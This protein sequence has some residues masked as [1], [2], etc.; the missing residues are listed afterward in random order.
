MCKRNA[1]FFR[2]TAFFRPTRTYKK[3]YISVK[4]IGGTECTCELPHGKSFANN[5]LSIACVSPGVT[6]Q[7]NDSHQ[8]DRFG[9]RPY[10]RNRFEIEPPRG[11]IVG[12]QKPRLNYPVKDTLK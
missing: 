11:K 2:N 9:N 5:N 8:V 1:S 10:A 6:S 3:S 12:K 7:R 4:V